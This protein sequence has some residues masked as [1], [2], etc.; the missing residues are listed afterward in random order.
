MQG[1][2]I[3]SDYNLCLDEIVKTIKS[4]D[5]EVNYCRICL[6]ACSNVI[7]HSRFKSMNLNSAHVMPTTQG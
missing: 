5:E 6:P 2:K 4:R 1:D 7:T 3:R